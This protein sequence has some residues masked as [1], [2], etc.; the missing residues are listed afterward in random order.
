MT[1][2]GCC[3]GKKKEDEE[4]LRQAKE[5][6]RQSNIQKVEAAIEKADMSLLW[7]YSFPDEKPIIR[8]DMSEHTICLLLPDAKMM[9]LDGDRGVL[10]WE[11]PLMGTFSGPPA[12]DAKRKVMYVTHSNKFWTLDAM[13]GCVNN[14]IWLIFHPCT[15]P[16]VTDSGVLLGAGDLNVHMIKPETG[17][18]LWSAPVGSMVIA[19]PVCTDSKVVA[20]G[21]SRIA[22]M[23]KDDGDLTWT[24]R[25]EFATIDQGAV[26]DAEN[27]YVGAS[28][29]AIYALNLE[30]G[31]IVWRRVIDGTPAQ[32]PI[33]KGEVVVAVGDPSG[34]SGL[35]RKTGNLL[36]NVSNVKS[37]IAMGQNNAYC[38]PVAGQT[39]IAVNIQTGKIEFSIPTPE[40][41]S[42]VSNPNDSL[43]VGLTHNNQLFAFRE[44]TGGSLLQAAAE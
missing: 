23:D 26:V 29:G 31:S 42:F 44:K 36:W 5:A 6:A 4:A 41:K 22:V 39:I 30:D 28:D 13:S 20:C 38:A 34:L 40:F 2:Q 17:M 27:A 33:I 19:P 12:I 8:A 7:Y 1:L 35:D 3:C 9:A 32:T 21:T 16:V 11:M 25:P 24:W 10:L 18:R 37:V 43:I 14:R 15:G